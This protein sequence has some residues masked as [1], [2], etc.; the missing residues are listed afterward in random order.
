MFLIKIT[1]L[2]LIAYLK[3]GL[4]HNKIMTRASHYP[5]KSD[6]LTPFEEKTKKLSLDSL[7]ILKKIRL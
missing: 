1:L 2:N 3:I 7:I 5:Q 6:I 4:I